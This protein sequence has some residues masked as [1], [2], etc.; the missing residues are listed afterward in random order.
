MF[1]Y[2]WAVLVY[3]IIFGVVTNIVIKNKGYEENWFWWGFFFGVFALIVACTKPSQVAVPRVEQ[4]PAIPTYVPKNM[5]SAKYDTLFSIPERQYS[6][7]SP[8]IIKAGKL[9]KERDTA[10]IFA[11]LDFQIVTSKKLKGVFVSV[12]E[13]DVAGDFLGKTDTQY[14]D[15]DRIAGAIFGS[16]KTIELSNHF[17]RKIE[18]QC[19]KVIFEDDTRWDAEG[20]WYQIP[21]CVSLSQK[22]VYELENQYKKEVNDN[23]CF[24]PLELEELWICS[25]G[26][27]NNHSNSNCIYCR[28]SKERV[29]TSLSIEE[30][31]RKVSERKARELEQQ[32]NLEAKKQEEAKQK[33]VANKK[34]NKLLA[35]AVAVILVIV[36]IVSVVKGNTNRAKADEFMQKGNHYGEFYYRDWYGD[37][38]MGEY[39]RISGNKYYMHQF[40]WVYARNSCFNERG[41]SYKVKVK[42]KGGKDVFYIVLEGREFEYNGNDYIEDGKLFERWED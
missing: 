35:I 29:F 18:V 14:L 11:N 15:L 13:Y 10:K 16:D 41:G 3:G 7:G 26:S 2:W 9:M 19:T 27:A 1:A 30:L 21:A 42:Q 20:D 23:A 32:R 31:Q 38:V 37:S 4:A 17:T 5:N 6:K 28:A 8:V 33:E 34:R 36:S 12:L 25:C 39:L 22:L 40:D 24:Y